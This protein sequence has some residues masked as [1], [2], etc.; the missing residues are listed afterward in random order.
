MPSGGGEAGGWP[1]SGAGDLCAGGEG[2]SPVWVLAEGRAAAGCWLGG[3][4]GCLRPAW[5]HPPPQLPRSD[6]LERQPD[7][8]RAGTQRAWQPPPS[9][10]RLFISSQKEEDGNRNRTLCRLRKLRAGPGVGPSCQP[11]RWRAP[12]EGCPTRA[13]APLLRPAGR[14]GAS[15]P[16]V[17]GRGPPQACLEPLPAGRGLGAASERRSM[18]SAHRCA[19]T[20]HLVSQTVVPLAFHGRGALVMDVCASQVRGPDLS[21]HLLQAW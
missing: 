15:W 17:D 16:R 6:F 13:G 8:D 2:P 3:R 9:A 1:P 7:S 11:T 12:P 21:R 14:S 19:L 4:R 5:H 20:P 18:P 10:V